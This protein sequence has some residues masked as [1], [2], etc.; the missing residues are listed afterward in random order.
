MEVLWKHLKT[1]YCL[2]SADFTAHKK[3]HIKGK[4]SIIKGRVQAVACNPAPRQEGG[5]KAKCNRA[6]P[7]C[8]ASVA[9]GHAR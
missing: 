6:G 2:F 1:A 3:V 9:Y 7:G 8:V 5:G 4:F